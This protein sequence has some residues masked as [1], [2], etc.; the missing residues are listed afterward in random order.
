M[1]TDDAQARAR[2]AGLDLIEISPNAQPP[3]CKIGDYGRLKY[4]QSK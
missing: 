3:V 1:P 4:E 2:V